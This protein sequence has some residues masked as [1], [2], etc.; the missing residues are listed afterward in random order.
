MPF[1]DFLNFNKYTVI[2]VHA[3]ELFKNKSIME[4]THVKGLM[5]RV[6]WLNFYSHNMDFEF[7]I[8]FSKNKWYP[9]TNGMLPP[10]LN[11]VFNID[12][13]IEIYWNNYDKNT[14]IGWRGP[15]LLWTDVLKSP[16]IYY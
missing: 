13:P 10:F 14:N 5:G 11:K 16:M 8:E 2:P 7:D 1:F 4:Y 9:L 6:K 15:M 3:Q 12:K